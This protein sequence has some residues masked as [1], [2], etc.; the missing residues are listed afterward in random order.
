M[1]RDYRINHR[2]DSPWRILGMTLDEGI[3]AIAVFIVSFLLSHMYIGLVIAVAWISFLKRIKKG[4]S[5]YFFM[6]LVYWHCPAS[7]SRL[8]LTRTPPAEK[9]FWLK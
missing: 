4:R 1:E 3:P 9:R 2:L 6:S 8:F 5:D 7:I